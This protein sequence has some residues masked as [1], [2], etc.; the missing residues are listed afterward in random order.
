MFG[1]PAN[2]NPTTV[3]DLTGK[4]VTDLHIAGAG[5]VIDIETGCTPDEHVDERQI[6]EPDVE[7]AWA[8]VAVRVANANR[9][10]GDEAVTGETQA[11]HSYGEDTERA[12]VYRENFMKGLPTTL[13]RLP[14]V[15][16]YEVS[17]VR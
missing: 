16:G 4:R 11:T 10:A 6:S 17:A 3:E 7:M 2:L 8:I 14:R 9:Q 13:L 5:S 1:M 15:V 12:A